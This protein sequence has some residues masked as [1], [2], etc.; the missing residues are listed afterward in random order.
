MHPH[1]GKHWARMTIAAP[2]AFEHLFTPQGL[3]RQFTINQEWAGN[4][5]QRFQVLVNINSLLF[6][7]LRKLNKV[8]PFPDGHSGK[9][10]D[11][12]DH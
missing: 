2:K 7:Y 8:E 1:I 6:R 10:P 11:T 9:L 12:G 5:P 3:F 4:R